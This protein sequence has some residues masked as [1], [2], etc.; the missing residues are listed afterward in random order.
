MGSSQVKHRPKVDRILLE[1]S[2]DSTKLF[3][4]VDHSLDNV[5]FT[6]DF[7]AKSVKNASGAFGRDNRRS[8]SSTN[9]LSHLGADIPAICENMAYAALPF[10]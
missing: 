7:F 8:P 1:T 3:K 9:L 6:I 2:C 10:Q 5:S 4:L